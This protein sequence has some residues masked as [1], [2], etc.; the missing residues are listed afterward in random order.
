MKRASF[1]LL[2]CNIEAP[3]LGEFRLRR[4]KLHVILE[5]LDEISPGVPWSASW[6]VVLSFILRDPVTPPGAFPLQPPKDARERR[7]VGTLPPTQF[8]SLEHNYPET[9][10]FRGDLS[11]PTICGREIITRL[12]APFVC[13]NGNDVDRAKRANSYGIDTNVTSR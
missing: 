10:K 7:N 3:L 13:I 5:F 8:F 2:R 12:P 1:E 6:C 11:S 9:A 4:E